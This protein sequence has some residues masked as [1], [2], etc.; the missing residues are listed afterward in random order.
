MVDT[1]LVMEQF[2]EI[3]RTL[4]QFAH[5]KLNMDESIA[6]SSIIDKLPP[7]W[8]DFKHKLKHKKEN[9]SLVELG[10]HL[11]IEQ[12]LCAQENVKEKE[13]S[14]SLAVNIMVEGSQ[15]M[16]NNKGK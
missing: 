4:E 14:N 13:T 7:A 15:K 10:K 16:N 5:D 2:H 1:R 9:I 11:H 8:E 6:V 12:G 3:Q